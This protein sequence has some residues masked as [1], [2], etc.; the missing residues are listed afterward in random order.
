MKIFL[1]RHHTLRVEDGAFSHKIEFVETFLRNF[2]SLLAS[3]LLYWLKSYGHFVER[4]NL[5]SSW[6]CIGKG[7]RLQP[8]QQACFYIK[9]EMPKDNFF[10]TQTRLEP[11]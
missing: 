7:L 1:Q 4:G 8:A 5:M 3:K 2:K 6:I 10:F 9:T 11:K